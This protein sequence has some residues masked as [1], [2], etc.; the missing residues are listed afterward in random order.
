MKPEGLGRLHVP[1]R[2][3][4]G[5]KAGEVFRTA[6]HL[7]ENTLNAGRES[8]EKTGRLIQTF[9][10]GRR[11]MRDWESGKPALYVVTLHEKYTENHSKKE[12]LDYVVGSSI[13]KAALLDLLALQPTAHLMKVLTVAKIAT[14]HT[15]VGPLILT[16]VERKIL[17]QLILAEQK[18]TPF[19]KSVVQKCE[20]ATLAV[21]MGMDPY[22]V[23]DPSKSIDPAVLIA[24]SAL[25]GTGSLFSKSLEYVTTKLN[26]R[27][28]N[29]PDPTDEV[30]P[31]ELLEVD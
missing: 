13:G 31:P 18:M 21:M 4:I 1:S 28:S 16:L 24:T 22:I 14:H 25:Q 7:P 23:F 15:I 17:N 19:E 30:I 10:D 3:Q 29:I 20:G 5:A 9:R 8:I 26:R 12:L 27:V 11:D 6:I 2:K